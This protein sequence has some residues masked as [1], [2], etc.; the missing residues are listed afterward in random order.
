MG[1]LPCLESG[2]KSVFYWQVV[3]SRLV[4]LLTG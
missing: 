1:W 3:L 4:P 2:G